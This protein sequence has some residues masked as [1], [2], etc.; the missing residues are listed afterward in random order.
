MTQMEFGPV[1]IEAGNSAEF[2]AK[3]I[4]SNQNLSIPPGATL[5][6]SYTNINNA[7]QTDTIAMSLINSFYI[8][9]W[10]STSAIYGLANWSIIATPNS[11]AAQIGQIRVI[12][13]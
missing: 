5:V 13:P 11:S 2:V 4:D 1:N 6:V 10:S 7:P 9:T 8:A 12:D 3:F